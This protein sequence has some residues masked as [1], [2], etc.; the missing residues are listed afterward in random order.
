MRIQHNTHISVKYTQIC[1]RKVEFNGNNLLRRRLAV[2]ISWL[3]VCQNIILLER[4]RCLT[5]KMGK[6]S[7]S[8]QCAMLKACDACADMDQL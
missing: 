1:Y 7:K 5:N 2:I 8:V 3:R 6:S 4:Y